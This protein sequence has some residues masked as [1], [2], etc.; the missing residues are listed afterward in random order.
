MAIALTLELEA[1]VVQ[2][3]QR[4]QTTPE[5]LVL[6][7]LRSHLPELVRRSLQTADDKI[8]FLRGIA[9]DCGVSLFN[10]AVSSE[11]LYGLM[12]TCWTPAS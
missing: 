11:G 4:L 8:A 3:A 10:E 2:Q 5:E 12:S 6:T 7:T 9:V 1:V